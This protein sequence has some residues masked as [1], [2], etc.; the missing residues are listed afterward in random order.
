MN[1]YSTNRKNLNATP[2]KGYHMRCYTYPYFFPVYDV[3]GY[4]LVCYG[5]VVYSGENENLYDIKI[6]DINSKGYKSLSIETMKLLLDDPGFYY[7]YG[8]NMHRFSS[9]DNMVVI[10]GRPFIKGKHIDHLCGGTV[11]VIN[12]DN[13]L[14]A[15]YIIHHGTIISMISRHPNVIHTYYDAANIYVYLSDIKKSKQDPFFVDYDQIKKKC[16]DE[17]SNAKARM[18]MYQERLDKIGELAADALNSLEDEFGISLEI[19]GLK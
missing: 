11:N 19:G 10:D 17:I 18:K 2:I 16:M 4:N 9:K 12:I 7:F 1:W 5:I 8:N 3:P 13:T 15:G 6:H 14:A